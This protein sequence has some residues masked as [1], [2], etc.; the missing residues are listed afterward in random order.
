MRDCVAVVDIGSGSMK[1]SIFK[2]MDGKIL[3]GAALS[4][5]FRLCYKIGDKIPDR[6][7]NAAVGFFGSVFE[8][9]K[10]HGV[11]NVVAVSTQAAR[12]APN[13]ADLQSKIFGKFGIHLRTISGT[14]EAKMT[15]LC[16]HM[17][18]KLDKFTSFDI[19]CGSVEVAKFDG[20]V[21]G[22]WSLPISTINLNKMRNLS[23]MES[24]IENALLG[25]ET[26]NDGALPAPLIGNG[27][28][29]KVAN[30]LIS[31][32][33]RNVLTCNE[34]EWLFSE[35]K[36]KTIEERVAFGVP[37]VR[38][39]IFPLGVLVTLRVAQHIGMD[40]LFLSGGN[41]RIGL[42]LEYFGILK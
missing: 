27:G 23:D 22:A 30:T 17:L 15:A 4:R 1:A 14:D 35:L 3:S 41:L 19:G 42:A 26:G 34:L 18:T 6:K 11:G 33:E 29:L 7:I 2:N 40:R 24:S 16:V 38:A 39:D 28:T 31:G 36:D 32:G 12:E 20:G 25:L 8:L 9:S 5:N 10:R 37:R 21:R 13:F